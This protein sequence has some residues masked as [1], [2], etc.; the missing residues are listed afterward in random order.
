MK[1][2]HF[3]YKAPQRSI[4]NQRMA[5]CWHRISSMLASSQRDANPKINGGCQLWLVSFW[6]FY[7]FLSFWI[8]YRCRIH[9]NGYQH[10]PCLRIICLLTLSL[11]L[12]TVIHTQKGNPKQIKTFGKINFRKCM[13]Y[14]GSF[15][16]HAAHPLKKTGRL[17]MKRIT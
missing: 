2:T 1:I 8:Y 15:K 7:L 12:K 10:F 17:G 6:H 5:T 3:L 4:D 9:S 11:Y 14:T 16:I 13:T